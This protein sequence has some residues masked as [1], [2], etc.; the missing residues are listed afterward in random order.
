M[1]SL[2]YAQIGGP[3]GGP[4]PIIQFLPLILVFLVFYFLLIRPQQKRAKE[5]QTMIDNLKRNDEVL[6]TGGLYGRVVELHDRVVTL[7]IA[8]R[9]QVRVDRQHI[10]AL[11]GSGRSGKGS[12][13][14]EREGKEK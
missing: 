11:A 9:V 14:E 10:D 4:N 8:P 6:T 2:A 7:E 3:T 5:R 13:A 1:A 12:G